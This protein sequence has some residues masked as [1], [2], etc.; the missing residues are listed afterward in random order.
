MDTTM[1]LR[2]AAALVLGVLV[3][4]QAAGARTL[5]DI[6]PAPDWPLPQPGQADP[7]DLQ[8]LDH[9]RVYLLLRDQVSLL[10]TVPERYVHSIVRVLRQTAVAD[11]ASIQIEVAPGYEQIRFHG[12]SLR[13]DGAVHDRLDSARISILRRES[14]LEHGL[15]DE[16]RTILLVLEDVRV[17][18]EVELAFTRIG[19]NPGL[20]GLYADRIAV[21]RSWPVLRRSIRVLSPPEHAPRWQL[22]G[23]TLA[24]DSLVEDGVRI[25]RWTAGP[26]DAVL[27]DAEAPAWHRPLGSLELSGARDWAQVAAWATPLYR[28]DAELDARVAIEALRIREHHAD[29]ESRL[30]EAVRFVQD[31]IRYTGLEIDAHSFV[32]HPVGQTLARRYGDCKDKT[33]LLIGLLKA[34]GIRSEAALVSTTS[35]HRL[36]DALPG[37]Y[38]FDHVIARV[39]FQG[40]DWWIDATNQFQRGRLHAFA[41]ADFGHALVLDGTGAGLT[42]MPAPDLEQPDT[43]IQ[44]TIE[45]VDAGKRIGGEGRVTIVTTYRG[46]RADEMRGR[47]ARSGRQVF[48][49]SYH[50]FLSGYYDDVESVK[51]PA[52]QDD[53]DENRFTVTEWYRLRAP[54]QAIDD[55][56]HDSTVWLTVLH[57]HLSLPSRR[58]R[59]APL[60]LGRPGHVRQQ[61]KVVLDKGW[62]RHSDRFEMANAFFS[63]RSQMELT[64]S[65]LLASGDVRFHTAEVEA[66]AVDGYVKALGDARSRMSYSLSTYAIAAAERDRSIPARAAMNPLSALVDALWPSRSGPADHAGVDAGTGAD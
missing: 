24:H 14:G 20:G 43:D 44:E 16:V 47:F 33:L 63:A 54:W 56:R 39:Q 53:E 31:E 61:I 21:A 15:V 62:T 48:E 32:P 66:D 38:A 51:P 60:A 59:A 2:L 50:N 42:A 55:E 23:A 46:V 13:R 4:A 9:D 3:L 27:H 36:P 65:S 7:A 37:P 34:L 25:D 28:P 10:G 6:G 17:G 45:L 8:G 18:D 64:D 5:Y 49:R 19:I 57:S 58:I 30:L 29:A 35:G 40:R 26:L 22:T 1:A 11:V 52:W 41:Q 12:I